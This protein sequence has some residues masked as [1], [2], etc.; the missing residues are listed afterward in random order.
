LVAS[1]GVVPV[2]GQPSVAS[3][4]VARSVAAASVTISSPAPFA[5]TRLGYARAQDLT[6]TNTGMAPTQI[7]AVTVNNGSDDFFVTSGASG[8]I[9]SCLDTNLVPQP[10]APSGACNLVVVF[11]PASFGPLSTVMTV[12]FTDGS[13]VPLNLSGTGVAGYYIA[14]SAAQYTTFGFA[15]NDLESAGMALNSPTLGIA[16][17]GSG[18]GFWLAA[19]DG[20]VFSAGDAVFLGSMGGRP[21]NKPVVGAGSTG[22]GNGYWLVAS[23]GG[24]FSFGDAAFFGSTGNIRLNKP[25]VGMAATPSGNGYWLVA[26]DGGIFT[27]GDARFFGS[28]GNIRLNKPIVGMAATPSGNGYWLVASDGGIF[29]FGDAAFFGST[30]AIRLNK[31]IVGML[32]SPTGRGYWMVA[33]DGGMFTFG[34]APFYGSLP[35]AGIVANDVIGMS[36]TAET[37]LQLSGAASADAAAAAVANRTVAARVV[38]ARLDRSSGPAR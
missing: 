38:D 13:A 10:I 37:P 24:I 26:S 18:N 29:T 27:F 11:L 33:S 4:D 8:A 23:D 7:S 34:D 21:L 3:A 25:V 20:G 35:A 2:A 1:L 5:V 14:R 6:V 9:P 31:P 16:D 12:S 17:T 36:G 19:S 15:P 28:T 32:A 22:D 30:G